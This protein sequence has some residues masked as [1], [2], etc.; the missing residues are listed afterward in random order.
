[1]AAGRSPHRPRRWHSP[2]R[3]PLGSPAEKKQAAPE[4]ASA[5]APVSMPPEPA[6]APQ[7]PDCSTSASLPPQA[8]AAPP[9]GCFQASPPQEQ[10]GVQKTPFH[11]ASLRSSAP[12]NGSHREPRHHR[13]NEN[14]PGLASGS[15]RRWHHKSR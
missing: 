11:R 4:Y 3:R 13:P 9:A 12:P 2:R 8:T 5:P 1:M 6:A 15:D 7:S 10:G 14:S